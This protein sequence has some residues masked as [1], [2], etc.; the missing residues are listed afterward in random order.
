MR[1]AARRGVVVR[2]EPAIG[3]DAW[4]ATWASVVKE[5]AARAAE[6]RE[7]AAGVVGRVEEEATGADDW[8]EVRV[9][10]TREAAARV[11]GRVAAEREVV[12]WGVATTA[13]EMSVGDWVAAGM[14]VEP[15]AV[16]VRV[17][18]AMAKVKKG[19][20]E[21]REVEVKEAVAATEP[22]GELARAA[23][24]AREVTTEQ[25]RWVVSKEAIAETGPSEELTRAA[26]R[27]REVTTEEEI[28]VV[29]KEAET[30]AEGSTEEP[31]TAVGR[32]GKKVE[33]GWASVH[34][35][36]AEEEGKMEAWRCRR[37][38]NPTH[39]KT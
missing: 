1:E 34:S 28:R 33:A 13:V 12:T 9:E 23:L 5:A 18:A 22:S 7:M 19:M 26:L 35:E 8:A 11:V 39:Q 24:R 31:W 3:A 2:Q 37:E 21:E 10:E 29:T 14:V 30:V 16:A 27:A 20:V 6:K 32:V 36:A 38:P 25:E 15:K 17:E 4:V